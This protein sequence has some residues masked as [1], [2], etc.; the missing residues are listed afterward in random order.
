MRGQGDRVE[1]RQ[2]DERVVVGGDGQRGAD[3]EREAP[4]KRPE[5]AG[6]VE[7][8]R[9]EQAEEEELRVGAG[10]LG[11]EDQIGAPRRQQ[12]HR[13]SRPGAVPPP[14]EQEDQ[15]HRRRPEEGRRPAQAEDGEAGDL[16]DEHV[17]GAEQRGVDALGM[18]E[19]GEPDDLIRPV[20]GPGL[21]EAERRRPEAGQ[22]GRARQGQRQGETVA[23]AHRAGASKGRAG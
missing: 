6:G 3:A 21:V 1:R 22:A 15:R 9:E 8:V 10:V 19:A 12:G 17:D 18:P 13:Q 14:H 16:R 7:G 20:P 23:L 4:R 5:A 11:I 2:I